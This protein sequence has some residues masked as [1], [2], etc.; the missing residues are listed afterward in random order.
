MN[1]VQMTSPQEVNI[2]VQA[3]KPTKPAEPVTGSNLLKSMNTLEVASDAAQKAKDSVQVI[4]PEAAKITSLTRVAPFE[5]TSCRNANGQYKIT[6]FK[7]G[8]IVKLKMKGEDEVW[9]T[10]TVMAD[11]ATVFKEA[12]ADGDG[13]L[14]F[15]EWRVRMS[16]LMGEEERR[17]LVLHL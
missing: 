14:T 9:W 15:D 5:T 13:K 17:I 6:T 4:P 11:L 7:A 12:D 3:E 16:R 10:A 2:S 8:D 1:Y